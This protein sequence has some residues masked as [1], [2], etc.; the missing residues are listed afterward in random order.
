MAL[1]GRGRLRV[2]RI[3]DRCLAI[4]SQPTG[5]GRHFAFG[6]KIMLQRDRLG[7]RDIKFRR[8]KNATTSATPDVVFRFHF[9]RCAGAVPVR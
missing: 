5:R 4:N 6:L 1:V 8:R 2:G 7:R 3:I 9:V